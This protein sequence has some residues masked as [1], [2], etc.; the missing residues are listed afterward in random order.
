MRHLKGVEHLKP[1]TEVAVCI[2]ERFG[3]GTYHVLRTIR[4]VDFMAGVIR[5][6]GTE[7]EYGLE[8]MEWRPVYGEPSQRLIMPVTDEIRREI[9]RRE[10]KERIENLLRNWKTVDDGLL[11]AM[12][13]SIDAWYKEKEQ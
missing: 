4:S 2:R 8:G 12:M 3:R 9:W 6:E 5:L 7:R 13:Q 11:R 10:T 1:G